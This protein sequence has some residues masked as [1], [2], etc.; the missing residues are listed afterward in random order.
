MNKKMMCLWAIA[1][2]STPATGFADAKVDFN[3]KCAMCHRTNANIVK[4]AQMLN[5]HP[6]KLALKN[7]KMTREE[8]IAITEKG[9][10]KMPGFEKELTRGQ[11]E[12]V[13]DY[14]LALKNRKGK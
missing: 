3:A 10:D 14:I 1:I 4:K 5:V 6:A 7:S 12:E 8:M 11:I 2:M 13:I 9:K